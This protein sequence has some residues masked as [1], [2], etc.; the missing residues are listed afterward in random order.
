MNK[1]ERAA[2]LAKKL[3]MARLLANLNQQQV[4]SRLGTSQAGVS[5]WETRGTDS[6]HVVWILAEIYH[7]EPFDL[8]GDL[9]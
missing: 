5:A 4:A 1:K 8:I 9:K 7:V 2:V 6:L 3:K